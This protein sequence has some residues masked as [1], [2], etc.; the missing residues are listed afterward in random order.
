[1]IT[2]KKGNKLFT[3]LRFILS[4]LPTRADGVRFPGMKRLQVEEDTAVATD[5]RR[6]HWTTHPAVAEL[7]TPGEYH[8][9]RNGQTMLQL[10]RKE[11]FTENKL[12]RF[13]EWRKAIPRQHSKSFTV[14]AMDA[15][16]IGYTLYAEAAINMGYPWLQSLLLLG[17]QEVEVL[18]SPE[19][20]FVYIKAVGSK[21]DVLCNAVIAGIMVDTIEVKTKEQTDGEDTDTDSI[22]GAGGE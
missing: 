16:R 14:S 3:P 13:P 22:D 8:V 5:S 2:I 1:M 11:F 12:V 7:F 21:K 15:Y 20:Y 10:E 9:V 19:S 18:F 17:D 4:A 6:V